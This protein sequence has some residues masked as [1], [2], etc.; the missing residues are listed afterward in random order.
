MS[1]QQKRKNFLF[2]GVSRMAHLLT[3]H[4]EAREIYT[5]RKEELA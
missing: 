5:K 4:G 2:E 1:D 3:E